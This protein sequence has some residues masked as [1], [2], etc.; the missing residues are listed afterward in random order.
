MRLWLIPLLLLTTGC[1]VE[2]RPPGGD[3]GSGVGSDGGSSSDAG[4][5]NNDP[6]DA[7]PIGL[8]SPGVTRVTLEV[9]YQA[10]AA[11]YTTGAVLGPNPWEVFDAN[12]E[13][14]FSRHPRTLVIPRT[15]AEME[16]VTVTSGPDFNVSELQA[17]A[18][19]HRDVPSTRTERSFYMLFLD[20]YFE[21]NGQRVS[22]VLGVSLGDG[23]GTTFLF[24][25]VIDS[26]S[27]PRETEQGTAIHE[28]GH[29]VGLVNNGVPLT[30][31]HQD[32]EHGAHCTNTGC[33]MFWQV[34]QDPNYIVNNLLGPLTGSNPVVFDDA[35]LDDA[36]AAGGP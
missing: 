24:K 16:Q 28:F 31:P 35:C 17:L 32:S 8:F 2:T 26:T 29:A 36:H 9:D 14:L 7:G 18:E 21:N 23:R 27:S 19:Q 33:V 15:L 11:P 3:G 12:A 6:P 25:P 4:N 1:I 30:T 13:A 22:N 10:G 5:P 20:G 34:D